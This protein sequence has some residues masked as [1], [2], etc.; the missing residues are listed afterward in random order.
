LSSSWSE[1][2]AWDCNFIIQRTFGGSRKLSLTFSW[3]FIQLLVVL[4]VDVAG[5]EKGNNKKAKG[6]I[7][8][9]AN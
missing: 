9:V 7:E 8:G 2:L 1:S 3:N 4:A 6:R 5:T